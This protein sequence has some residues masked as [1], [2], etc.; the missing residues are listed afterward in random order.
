MPQ[1]DAATYPSQIFWL[2][3]RPPKNEMKPSLFPIPTIRY[4]FWILDE[5]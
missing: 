5:G 1:F 4:Q 3:V 2:V